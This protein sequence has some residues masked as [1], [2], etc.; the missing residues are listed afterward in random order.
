[1]KGI[2]I[3]FEGPEGSG[4]STHALRIIRHLKRRGYDC[5]LVREPGTTR[6]GEMI[7]KVLLKSASVRITP[8]GEMMLFEAA[9]RQL[10][11]EIIRPA[12]KSG[13]VVISDRYYDATTAYQ[14]GGSG[15]EISFIR[16]LNMAATRG[17]KPD[18]TL[19]LDVETSEGLRRA[20]GVKQ[21]D[22]MEEKSR[23]YH[24]R[25]RKAYLGLAKKEPGRIKVIKARGA[26]DETA[27]LIK[28]VVEEFIGRDVI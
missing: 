8:F 23:A 2:F 5:L 27:R 1:M 25:V 19:L 14:G 13:R 11:D 24:R 28:K 7:R 15:I 6:L 20:K 18:L 12:L 4:K 16:K 9:R 21:Y 17:L 10:T 26:I 22:R 3:T